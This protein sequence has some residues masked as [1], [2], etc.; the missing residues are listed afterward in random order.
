MKFNF[1]TQYVLTS[2]PD[3]ITWVSLEPLLSDLRKLYDSIEEPHMQNHVATVINFVNSL[4]L[5]KQIQ[6]YKLPLENDEC[7]Y[8][9]SLH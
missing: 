1:Q 9:E 8:K 6:S 3:N 5:E 7:S 4:I 2:G